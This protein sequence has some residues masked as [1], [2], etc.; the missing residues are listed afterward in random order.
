MNVHILTI[1]DELLIGQ[2]VDT[3]SAWMGRE[4]NQIG[5]Q[6]TGISTVGDGEKDI[7]EA[8]DRCFRSA[9][10]MLVTGGLGPTKDDITKKVIADFFE[11]KLEFHPPS[12]ERIEGII[13]RFGKK[14]TEAHRQQAFMPTGAILLKNKMGSAPGMWFEKDG[15][16]LI[17]MPG[18]PREMKAVMQ[19]EVLPRLQ[20]QFPGTPIIHRTIRTVGEGESRLAARIADI[21]EQLPD[22]VKLAYLPGLG[23]V[24]LRLTAKGPD[25]AML[26]K[27]LTEE[28][29]KIE[30][31]ISEFIFGYEDDT[32]E[33]AIGQMLKDRQ[34]TLSTAESCT[35]GHLAHAITSISGSSA[36]FEGSVI[37]YANEV[38]MNLL[39]V[40]ESTLSE[41]GAVSET[42]VREMVAGAVQLLGTDVAMATSGIAGP[43]GGTPEKPVGTIWIAAGNGEKSLTKKLQLGRDRMVNI[44]YTTVAA[45]NLLRQFL[46]EMSE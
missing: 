4:L 38:K 27:T 6:V 24:R 44:Q 20:K 10:V 13:R 28:A 16:V 45:M 37:A 15:K 21:E 42:T 5:A 30:A 23:Q 19:D 3:N 14:T 25:K 35:G 18:V 12:F 46:K 43:G 22:F 39:G 2:V 40:N 36:Y 7:L 11:Q 33:K 34:L 31:R 32:L 1:G 41:H 9:D 26:Q 8:L 17:S 29:A